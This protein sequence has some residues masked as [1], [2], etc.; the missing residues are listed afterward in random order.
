[1]KLPWELEEATRVWPEARDVESLPNG[2]LEDTAH[3]DIP[4]RRNSI[5][6]QYFVCQMEISLV[7]NRCDLWL[8]NKITDQLECD[9]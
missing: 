3:R 4:G 5:I 7:T 6:Q 1:M 8:C 9:F 2:V